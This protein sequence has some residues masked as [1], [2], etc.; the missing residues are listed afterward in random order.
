MALQYP[1]YILALTMGVGKTALIGAIIATEF[2][3]ALEYSKSPF[4]ISQG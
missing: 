1:S 4:I 3:M 2:A